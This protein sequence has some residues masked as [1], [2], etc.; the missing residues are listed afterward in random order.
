MRFWRTQ[1]KAEVDFILV[2]EAGELLPIEV[3]Y[4]SFKAS[5]IPSGLKAFISNHKEVK[6]AFVLTKDYTGRAVYDSRC[7]YFLPVF[8]SSFILSRNYDIDMLGK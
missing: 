3:K 1:A 8:M 5:N 2:K 4:Q 6:T 7:I